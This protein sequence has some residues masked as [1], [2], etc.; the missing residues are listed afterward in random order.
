MSLIHAGARQPRAACVTTEADE[1]MA[2]VRERGGSRARRPHLPRIGD[3][4]EAGDDMITFVEN[5]QKVWESESKAMLALGEFLGARA[6]SMRFQVELMRM[7]TDTFRRYLLWSE[8]LLSLRPDT[9][10]Q[11]FMRPPSGGAAGPEPE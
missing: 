1:T 11:S 8:A 5:Y 9:F 10:L 2:E 7:G 4:I 3:L 6:E